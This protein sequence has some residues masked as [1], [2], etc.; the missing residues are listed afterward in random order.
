MKAMKMHN[1]GRARIAYNRINEI[2]K[3]GLELS[4]M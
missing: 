1:V 3:Q 2:D 4:E